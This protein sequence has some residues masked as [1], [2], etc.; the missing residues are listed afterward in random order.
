MVSSAKKRCP[1]GPECFVRDLKG[2]HQNIITMRAWSQKAPHP[3][4]RLGRGG[5][6]ATGRGRSAPRTGPE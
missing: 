5:L 1:K 3:H 2:Q 4:A 6:A